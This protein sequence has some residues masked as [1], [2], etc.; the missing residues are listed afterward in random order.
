[1]AD[2]EMYDYLTT[3]TPDYT[4]T[5]LSIRPQGEL[6]YTGKKSQVAHEMDDGSIAVISV[7]DNS[8]FD[9][10]IGWRIL[11]ESD[12]GTIMDF[13]HDT[14][15]ANGMEK[16]F[17]WAHPVDGHT[18]VAKFM[19]DFSGVFKAGWGTRQSVPGV[20][21]RIIGRKADA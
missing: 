12:A 4:A 7:S 15:K 19:S 6:K 8:Y 9:V 1:M 16:S 20:E 11:T 3:K 13:W 18:Y 17:Y 2:K 5:T 14:N 21:L 10:F